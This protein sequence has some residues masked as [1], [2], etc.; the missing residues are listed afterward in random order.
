MD[1]VGVGIY[2]I[3]DLMFRYVN[4]EMARLF[5]YKPEEMVDT[6]GP[7]DVTAAEHRGLV[8]EN[9]TRRA[10]G[11]PGHPYKIKCLRKDGTQFEAT[12]WG[13][14]SSF[15]GRDASVGTIIDITEQKETEE[16]R[17]KLQKQLVQAQKMESIVTLAGGIAHDFNN[18]LTIIQG[19]SEMVLAEKSPEHP[20]YSD[21][22]AVNTAAS[23]RRR[24]C[25]A[26]VDL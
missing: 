13:K 19:Y 4:P 22:S 7:V 16:E 25:Q 17:E 20:D 5:G 1:A 3:Q 8:R 21:L 10:E 23:A 15:Q 18:I 11:E 6:I 24:S 9:L 12:V 14:R 2:L 26:V